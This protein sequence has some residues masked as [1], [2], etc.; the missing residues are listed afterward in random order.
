MNDYNLIFKEIINNIDEYDNDN[1]Y[2]LNKKAYYQSLPFYNHSHEQARERA[3]VT[4]VPDGVRARFIRR[5]IGT[6]IRP[7]TFQQ[8]EFNNHAM[9]LIEAQQRFIEQNRA[10]I[11]E[12]VSKNKE[13]NKK[14]SEISSTLVEHIA[15]VKPSCKMSVIIN[16]LNRAPWLKRLL[17][18]L[19][20]QTYDNF[21]IIVV[22]GPSTD[23]TNEVLDTYKSIIKIEHCDKPNLSLSRNIGIKAA[24]GE[25]IVF[26]DDD[27]VPMNKYWLEQYAQS[28]ENATRLGATGGK[29]FDGRG[30]ELQ[31]DCPTID[32][33]G[34]PICI[35]GTQERENNQDVYDYIPG[36]NGAYLK[37]AVLEVGGFDEYI[38]YYGDESDL[39]I[40]LSRAGYKVEHHPAAH[41]FHENAVSGEKKSRCHMDWYIIIKN[42]I[43]FAYKNSE[44]YHDMDTRNTEAMKVSKK[45]L[46]GFDEYLIEGHITQKEHKSFVDMYERGV[47]QG[48]YD[49]LNTERA[50][51]FDLECT[52]EF[53]KI[54]KSRAQEQINLCFLLPNRITENA[55]VIKYTQEL[56]RHLITLNVNVHIVYNGSINNDYLA[57]GINYHSVYTIPIYIPSLEQYPLCEHAVRVS[58]S[59]YKRVKTLI[60][61]YNIS[62]IESPVWDACGLICAEMLNTPVLTRLQSPVKPVSDIGNIDKNED[63]QLLFV[64][65]KALMEKSAGIIAIGDSI[66]ETIS[67]LFDIGFKD[68]FNENFGHFKDTFT[69]NE[70]AEGALEIY[71]KTIEMFHR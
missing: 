34:Y 38:E 54:D 61:M 2:Y 36:G 65:E 14:L 3:S 4:N 53:L 6:L 66:P 44:G 52:Q 32:I 55:E 51:N 13:L 57:D 50:I 41:I 46:A 28:F 71:R 16:T 59:Q 33:W 30:G 1:S 8:T 62:I 45:I 69:Y 17:D 15:S 24:A 20:H 12:L 67:V 60:N 23:N 49:A 7:F 19:M 29:A 5:M 37:K 39:C 35:A 63:M 58:Y 47:K 68:K 70:I 48:K 40:R 64:L 25:I 21:E 31:L 26:I 27:A 42:Q 43:Y 11:E 56:A 22:N 18:A 9:G 10:V